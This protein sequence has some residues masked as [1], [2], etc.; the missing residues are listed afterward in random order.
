MPG[1]HGFSTDRTLTVGSRLTARPAV[2]AAC[3]GCGHHIGLVGIEHAA[4]S[5]SRKAAPASKTGA[6]RLRVVMTASR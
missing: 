4:T 5:V 6:R 2:C 1:C 3:F